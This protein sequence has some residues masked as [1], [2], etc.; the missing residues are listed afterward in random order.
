MFHSAFHDIGSYPNGA[1]ASDKTS[2]GTRSS[3][4]AYFQRRRNQNTLQPY[5]FISM[6]VR[7]KV[8]TSLR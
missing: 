6:Q 8:L 3:Y 4:L 2:H 5:I 7:L 1:S